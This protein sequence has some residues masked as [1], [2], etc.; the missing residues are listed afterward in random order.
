MFT[1]DDAPT[2]LK[3]F[4]GKS[5][6]FSALLEDGQ[7]RYLAET[8]GIIFEDSTS[9]LG[10]TGCAGGRLTLDWTSHGSAIAWW[11][12]IPLDCGE[13]RFIYLPDT[14]AVSVDSGELRFSS[15][16]AEYS[17]IRY[18]SRP[19]PSSIYVGQWQRAWYRHPWSGKQ[20][21]DPGTTIALSSDGSLQLESAYAEGSV[22]QA[23]E[24]EVGPS[25]FVLRRFES[26]FFLPETYLPPRFWRGPLMSNLI[27]AKQDSLI[28]F[29][30][31]GNRVEVYSRKSFN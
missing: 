4:F 28:V 8:H 14:F 23:G 19:S 11:S 18:T 31:K 24:W 2:E 12:G 7:Q 9:A 6:L 16:D 10:D 25:G 13:P 20:E 3:D 26:R 27:Q 15:P 30:G 17:L 1:G 5:L 22:F 29:D 21:P